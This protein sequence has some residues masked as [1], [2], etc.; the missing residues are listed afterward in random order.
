M[1][2]GDALAAAVRRE[3]GGAGPHASGF[4][5]RLTPARGGVAGSMQRGRFDVDDEGMFGDAGT[6]PVAGCARVWRVCGTLARLP[7]SA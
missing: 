6:A 1:D 4:G 7:R 5:A 3:H 2:G